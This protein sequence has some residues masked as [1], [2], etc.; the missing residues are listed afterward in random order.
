MVP[1]EY[2]RFTGN[3][4]AQEGLAGAGGR[5]AIGLA[6]RADALN[7]ATEQLIAAITKQTQGVL[8]AL[9]DAAFGVEQQDRLGRVL[10]QCSVARLSLTSG[11]DV[12]DQQQ[13]QRLPTTTTAHRAQ[14]DTGEDHQA[15]GAQE[16]LVHLEAIA[17]AQQHLLHMG[18]LDRQ[19]VRVRQLLPTAGEQFVAT[20]TED[21]AQLLIDLFPAKALGG[22]CHA[23]QRCLEEQTQAFIS[24]AQLRLGALALADVLHHAVDAHQAAIV[25]ALGH[26]AQ[27]H[28]AS[29]QAC[30]Q[31]HLDIQIIH[32]AQ[33]CLQGLHDQ[34]LTR[35]VVVVQHLLQVGWPLLD[36]A[37]D[38]AVAA[39]APEHAV[40]TDLQHPASQIGDIFGL[41]EQM[42]LTQ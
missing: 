35:C 21:A 2:R 1:F 14:A 39:I 22:Q 13:E 5:A 33:G 26:A 27:A 6:Q 18:L 9:D 3:S 41:A 42:T 30:G 10:D 28:Q 24:L 11:A 31:A 15:I 25:I 34:R 36:I 32:P 29:A 20:A 19:I 8:I 40:V 38:D 16:A 37:V 7:R 4:A 12:L 23:D 17:A